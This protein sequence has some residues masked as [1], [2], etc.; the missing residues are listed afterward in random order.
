MNIEQQQIAD[1]Q[2]FAACRCA[3]IGAVMRAV[4]AGADVKG[5]DKWGRTPL[6]CL[7]YGEEMCTLMTVVKYLVER[8]ADVK[9]LD[10]YGR[11]IFSREDPVRIEKRKIA[12][13]ALFD[14]AR[15]CCIGAA[16]RAVAAGADVNAINEWGETPMHCLPYGQDEIVVTTIIEYLTLH[17]KVDVR[18]RDRY[19]R[20][21]LMLT[22]L[23]AEWSAVA[24]IMWAADQ[25][26]WTTIL[27]NEKDN[28]GST[29]LHYAARSAHSTPTI[30][31]L[32]LAGGADK[33]IKDKRG[34]IPVMWVKGTHKAKEEVL[35]NY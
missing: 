14:A 7:P 19:G 27:V 35:I 2:L 3:C 6:H 8:G 31:G 5:R 28:E 21:T 33:N 23:T 10:D 12:N 22:S 34:F 32:L 18:I 29:A 20:S 25:I 15:H 11:S 17:C 13:K 30:I 1:E 26:G 16:M 9:A 24:Q 4:A